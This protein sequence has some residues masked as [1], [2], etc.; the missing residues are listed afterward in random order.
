MTRSPVLGLI[1]WMILVFIAAGLGGLASAQAGSF[2]VTLDQPPWAPPSW[3][4]GP[5]WSLLY[6]MMGFAAWFIWKAHGFRGAPWALGLFLVQLALN[7]LWTWLFF[8]WHLGMWSVV[9]IAALWLL[10]LCT[11]IAFWRR[12]PLAGILLVPYIVW[13]TFA[14]VLAYAMWARNPT[15]LG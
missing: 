9:E 3:L 10:I 2:Y 11:L 4:F 6:L 14:S 15:I 7:A 8:A 5:V 13:V 12:R 1:G